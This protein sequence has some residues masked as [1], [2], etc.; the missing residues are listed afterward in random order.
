MDY[1]QVYS[2]LQLAPEKI[3]QTDNLIGQITTN[4]GRYQRVEANTGIPWWL[5][6]VIHASAHSNQVDPN[7]VSFDTDLDGQ[8]IEG[9]WEQKISE[10][11]L[12][13]A[14]NWR[15]LPSNNPSTTL[16]KIDQ[17]NGNQEQDPRVWAGTDQYS[18]G[19]YDEKGGWQSN[20]VAQ[21]VGGVALYK[22]MVDNGVISPSGDEGTDTP[23]LYGNHGTGC[24]DTGV[25]NI[26]NFAGI[27]SPTS[28]K[29]A[30]VMAEGLH[31]MDKKRTF[32]MSAI[33]DVASI[34]EILVLEVGQTIDLQGFGEG[35]DGDDWTVEEL[36]YHFGKT[37]ELEIK[38]FA[39]DPPINAI[40]SISMGNG[41]SAP[42]TPQPMFILF[43]P[44]QGMGNPYG[45]GFQ[46]SPSQYTGYGSQYNYQSQYG[47]GTF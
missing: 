28:K 16:Q 19:D 30:Q 27:H 44:Y 26:R 3:S 13:I 23:M 21:G 25:G 33:I 7:Q 31:G 42:P 10:T 36:I 41:N 34:P 24:I 8:P 22:R 5:V 29:D 32:T 2:R 4:K 15:S 11:L 18:R 17:F 37:L 35:I 1:S 40:K 43:N 14:N 6:G 46:N 12:P 20:D 47:Y 9:E 38:A 45:S 39:G